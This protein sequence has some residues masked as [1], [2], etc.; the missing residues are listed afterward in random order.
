MSTTATQTAATTKWNLDL[1]HSEI[2]FKV[3]HLMISTVTGQFKNFTVTA[4][5]GDDFSNPTGIEVVI[6]ANSIDTRSEQRDGH[7]RSADFFDAEKFPQLVFKSTRY[8]DDTLYGQLTI[9]GVTKDI[10]LQVEP[11]GIVVDPYGQTK[12]GFT[13]EGK[14]S[15]KDFGLTWSAVTEA[16]QIVV[17]DDVKFHAEIQL[18]KQ[19]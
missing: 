2:G 11:G 18:V 10:A 3:K 15:R 9:K 8:E 17:G 12:A 4:Q 6:E 19:S 14:F 16:G 7:L 13:V 1:S 5:A